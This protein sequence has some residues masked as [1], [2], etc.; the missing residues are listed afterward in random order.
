MLDA[1]LKVPEQRD[2]INAGS[3]GVR[4]DRT[5]SSFVTPFVF[6][7]E[8]SIHDSSLESRGLR[9]GNPMISAPLGSPKY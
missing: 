3:E 7:G 4:A 9:K 8:P 5:E 1:A 2:V 6:R